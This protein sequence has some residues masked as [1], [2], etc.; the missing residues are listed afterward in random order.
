VLHVVVCLGQHQ[1]SYTVV[2]VRTQQMDD[3][4]LRWHREH[5]LYIHF[6][7]LLLND[8]SL[9]GRQ[10]Q[11]DCVIET[12]NNTVKLLYLARPFRRLVREELYNDWSPDPLPFPYELP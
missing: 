6:Y 8:K 4:V 12:V 1:Y 5:I 3:E 9:P 11:N 2:D 7:S 10:N